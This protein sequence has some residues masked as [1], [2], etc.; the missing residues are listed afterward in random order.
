MKM[1]YTS[2]PA[3]FLLSSSSILRRRLPQSI[4]DVYVGLVSESFSNISPIG[5]LLFRVLW[6][7][8][9]RAVAATT[10]ANVVSAGKYV[11][12]PR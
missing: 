12:V 9:A 4:H 6:L 2:Y 8:R 7:F 1:L 10:T 11:S 5:F 3:P